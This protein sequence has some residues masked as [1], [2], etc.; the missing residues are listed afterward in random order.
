MSMKANQ[1]EIL[2]TV[3]AELSWSHLRL[4]LGFDEPLQ[5]DYYIDLPFYHRRLKCLVAIEL[6]SAEKTVR[7]ELRACRAVEGRTTDPQRR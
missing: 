4:L 3:C 1:P 6:K 5:R 7:P 2:H